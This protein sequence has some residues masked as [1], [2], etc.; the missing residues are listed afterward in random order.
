VQ[1]D[2]PIEFRK[3]CRNLGQDLAGKV[4]AMNPADATNLLV[5]TATIGIDKNEAHAIRAF[6]SDLL[7]KGLTS[8]Q[9]I[10]F[11]RKTPADIYF[12]DGEQV[13]RFL[14][15]LDASLSRPPYRES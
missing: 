4:R 3:A 8:E 2:M 15:S 1:I 7:S 6:V 5:Q 14:R 10:E 13:E 12:Y 11:W 9:L